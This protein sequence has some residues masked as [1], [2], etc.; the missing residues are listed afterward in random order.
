M[1]NSYM[2]RINLPSFDKR[3]NLSYAEATMFL[4]ISAKRLVAVSRLWIQSTSWEGLHHVQHQG[5]SS[6]QGEH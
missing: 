6:V 1:L 2:T 5:I 3:R 4:L